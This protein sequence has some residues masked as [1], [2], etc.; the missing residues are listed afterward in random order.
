MENKEYDKIYFIPKLFFIFNI[1][2]K[3]IYELY[4]KYLPDLHYTTLQYGYETNVL[5]LAF[6]LIDI[7]I[8]NH[9]ENTSKTSSSAQVIFLNHINHCTYYL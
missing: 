4:F 7:Q 5:A 2:N 9:T 6:Q 1:F 3:I 8:A